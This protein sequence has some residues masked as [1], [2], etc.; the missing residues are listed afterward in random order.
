MNMEASHHNMPFPEPAGHVFAPRYR[1][2]SVIQ[3]EKNWR[4]GSDDPQGRFTDAPA[5]ENV[6]P[7]QSSYGE[8]VSP[9]SY[10]SRPTPV[11]ATKPPHDAEI[12]RVAI[13]DP[14]S[15]HHTA[16]TPSLPAPPMPN[17]PDPEQMTREECC[18]QDWIGSDCVYA[19]TLVLF[20]VPMSM[21][22]DHITAF[23]SQFGQVYPVRRNVAKTH[24]MVFA[25]FKSVAGARNC[26]LNRPDHWPDGSPFRVQVSKHFWDPTHSKYIFRGRSAG[27]AGNPSEAQKNLNA[28][29]HSILA[30]PEADT[31]SN[32][33]KGNDQPA[34]EM[35]HSGQ[36]TPTLST[37]STPKKTKK[38]PKSSKT[39]N[40]R[41]KDEEDLRKA[42]QS[43]KLEQHLRAQGDDVTPVV[44]PMEGQKAA[45]ERPAS[46]VDKKKHLD[47]D[48]SLLPNPQRSLSVQTEHETSSEP[49]FTPTDR[50]EA[51]LPVTISHDSDNLA[52]VVVATSQALA[53]GNVADKDVQDPASAPPTAAPVL[54]SDNA[55][56]VPREE[57]FREA[58]KTKN[59][60]ATKAAVDP[61]VS[62]TTT[63]EAK[64]STPIKRDDT[65]IDDSFHT[66][67]GS[68]DTIKPNR[69]DK[70]DA[71]LNS[72]A[73]G[74]IYVEDFSASPVE[75]EEKHQA[76]ADIGNVPAPPTPV[77]SSDGSE[78]ART[79]QPPAISTNFPP[80]ADT[81]EVP[82]HVSP[83]AGSAM[84]TPHTA[85]FTA[86]NTPAV[87][88]ESP[89]EDKGKAKLT[90]LNKLN[91]SEPP[92][93]ESAAP[94]SKNKENVAPSTSAQK[95]PEKPEKP[96]GPAQT[97]SLSL[98]GK[99]REKEKKPKAVKQAT[100]KGK[101]KGFDANGTVDGGAGNASRAASIT[102][103]P[104]ATE[105]TEATS[106]KGGEEMSR[107]DSKMS[108][109]LKKRNKKKKETD[110][111]QDTG[112]A[113]LEELAARHEPSQ[114]QASPTKRRGITERISEFFRG[115]QPSTSPE[116]TAE[117]KPWSKL[118][119]NDKGQDRAQEVE[120]KVHDHLPGSDAVGAKA[121]VLTTPAV[122]PPVL[123]D[124]AH[125]DGAKPQPVDEIQSA[126]QEIEDAETIGLGIVRSETSST[127]TSGKESKSL[128]K[129]QKK[130]LKRRFARLSDNQ[131]SILTTSDTPVL[132]SPTGRP[133]TLSEVFHFGDGGIIKDDKSDASSVTFGRITPT[134]EVCSPTTASNPV[135][136]LPLKTV[137]KGHLVEE[138]RPRWKNKKMF[139][140]QEIQDDD[141]DNEEDDEDEE[142]ENEEES[143]DQA[144]YVVPTSSN[145]NDNRTS[146]ASEALYPTIDDKVFIYLG[147]GQRGDMEREDAERVA[148]VAES[149][150]RMAKLQQEEQ[151]AQFRQKLRKQGKMLQPALETAQ[152]Q[153]QDEGLSPSVDF[154]D[155]GMLTLTF[156]AVSA[157]WSANATSSPSEGGVLGKAEDE[158]GGGEGGSAADPSAD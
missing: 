103:Q 97:E 67:S 143:D 68:P 96:K 116:K 110:T 65:M 150:A 71:V 117:S 15:A 85:Y 121:S 44:K 158:D 6:A 17:L 153:T 53:S 89:K 127:S 109:T 100:L 64:T 41:Q 82:Q 104:K 22:D 47:S 94:A 70:V 145:S 99:K 119:T 95:K 2:E 55:D 74:T 63:D 16:R 107:T 151:Q 77:S 155:V 46:A 38:K 147:P 48:M 59:E 80:K 106:T 98:F 132:S 72:T 50:I 114:G 10:Q 7:R 13:S 73:S 66:A 61:D 87:A 18:G 12:E 76:D 33:G 27:G 123:N 113:T 126:K 52:P 35:Q 58:Q 118:L 30:R 102:A 34:V 42:S 24:Q 146:T 51:R 111:A 122:T 78:K 134:S 130:S 112:K 45:E 9:S 23:M 26:I 11:Y 5:D 93:A 32:Q 31:S 129:A 4:S 19:D 142:Q 56:D 140:I 148:R 120:Q 43:L 124:E 81:L 125:S 1:R 84:P 83:G 156:L 36:T 138:K 88:Q 69:E 90:P 101:P 39:K 141:D 28:P 29:S 135:R 92:R 49:A 57:L 136:K 157:L 86:P 154:E 62:F 54:K 21:E 149:K 3:E 108:N 105:A 133:T 40:H 20:N 137:G 144:V 60:T 37:A 14:P 152:T 75:H 79:P 25:N 115:G 139:K 131:S 128:T 91:Q 8:M